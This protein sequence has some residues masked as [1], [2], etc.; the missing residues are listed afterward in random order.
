MDFGARND[1]GVPPARHWSG[2]VHLPP[3]RQ[4]GPRPYN[5]GMAIRPNHLVRLS[6]RVQVWRRAIRRNN[7]VSRSCDKTIV[8]LSPRNLR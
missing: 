8:K 2:M 1:G 7:G 6:D 5:T 4:S 3:S